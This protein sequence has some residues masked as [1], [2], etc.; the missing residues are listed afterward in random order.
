MSGALPLSAPLNAARRKDWAIAFL[1][2]SAALL[3]FAGARV[4]GVTGFAVATV[5]AIEVEGHAL[6]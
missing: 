2:T 6:F 3:E 1:P 4:F 5:A